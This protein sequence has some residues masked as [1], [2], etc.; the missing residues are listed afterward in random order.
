MTSH[1]PEQPLGASKRP[2][3]AGTGVLDR[4][5]STT[6]ALLGA[7]AL[8]GLVIVAIMSQQGFGLLPQLPIPGLSQGDEGV[9]GADALGGSGDS[10]RPAISVLPAGEAVGGQGAQAPA[11]G[12][13]GKSN[14]GGSRQLDSGGN[15]QPGTG[16]PGNQPAPQPTSTP[17]EPAPTTVS[18]PTT[19]TPSSPGSGSSPPPSTSQPPKTD[20][21]T[22]AIGGS[23]G[24]GKPSGGSNV[25]DSVKQEAVTAAP[26]APPAPPPAAPSAPAGQTDAE[27]AEALR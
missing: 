23:T 1:E 4:L 7:T 18:Q 10:S 26:T 15:P 19:Q 21:A 5:R 9:S 25:P 14:L 24:G 12:A 3:L 2:S 13:Q 6:F 27:K 11:R 20:A 8:F 22:A 17:T 16:Q